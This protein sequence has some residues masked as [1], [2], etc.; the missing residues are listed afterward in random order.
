MAV[1]SIAFTETSFSPRLAS[2]VRLVQELADE[3][4]R[5]LP[6]VLGDVVFAMERAR[7][8]AL[9]P[10]VGERCEVI[11]PGQALMMDVLLASIN[12]E[13]GT[14]RIEASPGKEGIDVP[15]YMVVLRA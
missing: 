13:S 2:L 3:D 15:A 1:Q 10:H 5:M 7:A 9:R 8:T 12:I 14:A 6:T 11:W 4:M